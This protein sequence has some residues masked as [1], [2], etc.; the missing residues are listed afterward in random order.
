MTKINFEE[1]SAGFIE[2]VLQNVVSEDLS[3][4]DNFR[5]VIEETWRRA[6]LDGSSDLQVAAER[7]VEADVLLSK[8]VA[9]VKTVIRNT[10]Q[11]RN[12]KAPARF[13]WAAGYG[14]YN[15][16]TL[17]T[18]TALTYQSPRYLSHS[19]ARLNGKTSEVQAHNDFISLRGKGTHTTEVIIPMR[20]LSLSDGDLSKMV[21]TEVRKEAAEVSKSRRDILLREKALVEKNLTKLLKELEEMEKKVS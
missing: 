21:R 2:H 3:T 7:Y 14:E 11:K 8:K 9:R 20:W 18:N 6:R 15:I 12:L 19:L 17:Y 4:E 13:A 16:S 1:P 5:A 10:L